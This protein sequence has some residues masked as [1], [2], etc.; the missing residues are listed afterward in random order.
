[1]LV[2]SSNATNLTDGLDGLAVGN[3][4]I[5]LGVL[6]VFCYLA[7]TAP[8]AKYLGIFHVSG[9][10]ELCVPLSALCGSCMGFLWHN[11]YPASTFMG[12]TGSLGMGAAIG[13]AGLVSKQEIPFAIASGV[14]VLEALSVLIQRYYFK[15]S[16]GKRIFRM[17]PLHHHFELIGW[18]EPKVIIRF[19]IFSIILAVL[20][21]STLKIR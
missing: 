18:S 16:G 7:G 21:L 11:C 10:A 14:L 9:V 13:L 17:A 12:D 3:L 19:W 4:M 6:I 8:V 5:I 2:G 20:A 15:I 1:V